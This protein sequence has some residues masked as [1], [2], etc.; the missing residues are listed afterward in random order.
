[1]QG[2]DWHMMER[3]TAAMV[4]LTQYTL[5]ADLRPLNN[6]QQQQQQQKQEQQREYQQQQEQEQKH[7]LH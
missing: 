4:V 3:K 1:M 6:F 7:Q 2:N 5:R